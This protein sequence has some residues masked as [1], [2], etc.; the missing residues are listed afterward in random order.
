MTLAK[1]AWRYSVMSGMAEENN[2]DIDLQGDASWVVAGV[3]GHRH[4]TII[5]NSSRA[6]IFRVLLLGRRDSFMA[7]LLTAWALSRVPPSVLKLP[8][9][10]RS[11]NSPPPKLNWFHPMKAMSAK[12][13]SLH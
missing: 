13:P 4:D 9:T 3:C 1:E 6:K 8:L 11:Q 7:A 5:G 10:R 12:S 2:L